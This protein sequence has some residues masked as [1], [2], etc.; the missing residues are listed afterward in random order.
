MYVDNIDKVAFLLLEIHS[1]IEHGE[2]KIEETPNQKNK[3]IRFI[4]TGHAT[5]LISGGC[6]LRTTAPEPNAIHNSF[7]KISSPH[8]VTDLNPTGISSRWQ[9][10]SQVSMQQGYQNVSRFPIYKF[11]RAPIFYP[12]NLDLDAMNFAVSGC[13]FWKKV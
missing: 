8:L 3:H 11:F 10:A 1:E 5:W 2:A 6:F 9:L 4:S 12:K 7:R 13:Q